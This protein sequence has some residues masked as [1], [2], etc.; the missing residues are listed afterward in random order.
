[1]ISHLKQ[2][3]I[4]GITR[5][6][7]IVGIFLLC[8]VRYIFFGTKVISRLIDLIYENIAKMANKIF[9]V[10]NHLNSKTKFNINNA[11]CNV[12]F[13]K[14]HNNQCKK[15]QNL[16]ILELFLIQRLIIPLQDFYQGTK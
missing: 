12:C 5:S 11:F 9:N 14:I 15:A 6:Y 2:Y 3:I 1:M 13:T 4:D 16:L 8:T 10:P 7:K